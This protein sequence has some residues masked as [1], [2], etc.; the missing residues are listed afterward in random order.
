MH[1]W[2][3]TA[4]AGQKGE[5]SRKRTARTD[6]YNATAKTKQP[7][8]DSQNVKARTGQTDQDCRYRTVRTV[9]LRQVVRAGQPV[10]DS[11]NRT[12]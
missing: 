2:D 12:G 7:E 9:L 5:N 8:Q 10:Q 6:N 11:Q 3:K 1:C 4:R